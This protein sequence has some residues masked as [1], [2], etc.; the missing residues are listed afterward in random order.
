MWIFNMNIRR[1]H[2]YITKQR[3][4][5]K[6]SPNIYIYDIDIDIGPST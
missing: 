1:I 2:K 6:K 3:Y 4:Q 5:L